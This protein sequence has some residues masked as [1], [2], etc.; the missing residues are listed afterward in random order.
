MAD[1]AGQWA[2]PGVVL[3]PAIPAQFK[4]VV[5]QP[6][7]APAKPI[8]SFAM[9]ANVN[10]EVQFSS[11][12]TVFTSDLTVGGTY[13]PSRPGSE[14]QY[15]GNLALIYSHRITP[16]LSFLGHGEHRVPEPAEPAARERAHPGLR[17][18]HQRE[19]QVQPV[20][21]LDR[22]AFQHGLEPFARF[23]DFR[24]QSDFRPGSFYDVILGTEARY[25]WSPRLTVLGEVRL[26]A[27]Q[28][29]SALPPR[30]AI[31][32]ATSC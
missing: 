2:A 29:T 31:P 22:P 12:R 21:P 15:N 25:L 16:R 4:T 18:L 5:V 10:G 1:A 27:P 19:L 8:G 24:E 3:V 13:Y 20:V 28:T 32:R 17:R 6:A 30:I 9:R 11:R 7:V 14:I 26:T 23:A